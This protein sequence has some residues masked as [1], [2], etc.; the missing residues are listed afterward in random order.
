MCAYLRWLRV[1]PELSRVAAWGRQS[2]FLVA[3]PTG[4]PP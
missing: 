1:V 4:V 3:G 2:V